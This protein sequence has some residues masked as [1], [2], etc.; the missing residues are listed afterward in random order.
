[1]QTKSILFSFCCF[2]ITNMCIGQSEISKKELKFRS[3][4]LAGVLEGEKG[5]FF[6][7]QWLNGINYKTWFTGIG[8]G[9]D[10]YYIRSVPFVLQLEKRLSY[11]PSSFFVYGNGGLNFHWSTNKSD[12]TGMKKDWIMEIG[13]GYKVPAFKKNT[14][15]LSAGY[16]IKHI[17]Q[18]VAGWP[19]TFDPV[20]SYL[21]YTQHYSYSFRILSIKM[22]IEF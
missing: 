2:C 13:A 7:L 3:S 9:L 21:D 6:Q 11:K 20:F 18:S 16:S 5:G 12:Q 19:V 14:F 15:L 8:I 1:M 10:H 4:V 22:G 17:R